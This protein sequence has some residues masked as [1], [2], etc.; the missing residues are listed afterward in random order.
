MID[1]P[2]ATSVG[3]PALFEQQPC[4][5]DLAANR[6][7][8]GEKPPENDFRRGDHLRIGE[9]AHKMVCK[10]IIERKW[11]SAIP[12]AVGAHFGYPHKSLIVL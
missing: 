3:C 9:R 1:R 11:N 6:M 4:P 10:K 8:S 5:G 2:R 7:I 12:F